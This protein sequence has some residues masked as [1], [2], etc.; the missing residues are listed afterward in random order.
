[1]SIVAPG[2]RYTASSLGVYYADQSIAHLELNLTDA[3]LWEYIQDVDKS[4]IG[5]DY[6]TG[7]S[8]TNYKVEW[9]ISD[10]SIASFVDTIAV[11]SNSITLR[12]NNI[13]TDSLVFTVYARSMQFRTEILLS[14]RI[15][16]RNSI[17][18][19]SIQILSELNKT[20]DNN[21]NYYLDLKAG[22]SVQIEARNYSS[23]GDVTNEDVF[24]VVADDFG[25]QSRAVTVD[26]ITKTITAGTTNLA[27]ELNIIIF[28][29]FS[30]APFIIL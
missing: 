6:T 12:F 27:S 3:S 17:V 28:A 26:N 5:N 25:N 21:E 8:E 13:Q 1:M 23:L 16:V 4:I 11:T 29:R 2:D 14:T 19:E 24:I 20:D 9:Y 22:E 15:T 30:F 10:E 7:G 18:T